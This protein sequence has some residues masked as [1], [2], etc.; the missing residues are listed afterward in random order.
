MNYIQAFGCF[1][2]GFFFLWFTYRDKKRI[3][4][5]LTFEFIADL[6]GYIG[7]VIFIIL[8]LLLLMGW[9]ND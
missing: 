1:A 3:K 9:F 6:K 7:S 8:G 5:G 4:F 2:V